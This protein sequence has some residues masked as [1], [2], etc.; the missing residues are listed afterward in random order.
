MQLPL[1][2]KTRM[3]NQLGQNF[4]KFQASLEGVP[5]VSIR[6]NPRKVAPIIY[7]RKQVVWE[8]LAFYLNERP[9][10]T[11]DPQFHAGAYYVQEASSMFVGYVFKQ[12][13]KKNTPLKILDLCGAPGGKSTH[14]ASLMNDSS[15]LV[16][17]E[18][19]KTR[20]AVLTENLI[21]LGNPNLV[22]TQND[23]KDFQKLPGFF[24]LILVDAPC[25]GEGLFRRD[26]SAM[27]EW[28]VDN[29]AICSQRQQRILADVWEALAPGGYLIYSTCTYNPDENERNLSW[30]T[31]QFDAVNV[32]IIIPDEWG[33][34]KINYQNIEAYQFFPHNIEG[35]GFFI[36]VLQKKGLEQ[37]LKNRT[38]KKFNTPGKELE[39]IV[40]RWLVQPEYFKFIELNQT[41]RAIPS[42]LQP[43]IELLSEQ[44]RIVHS[45]ILIAEIKGKKLIPQHDLSMS[46]FLNKGQF[47]LILLDDYEALLYLKK[48]NVHSDQGVR[49]FNI[50]MH[51]KLPLGFVNHLGNRSNNNYPV[52]WRIRMNLPVKEAFVPHVIVKNQEI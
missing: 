28:S 47:P 3:Q 43:W 44:L 8:P 49:G 51:D 27:D 36:G 2:F 10:F 29:A 13:F 34:S 35:E 31:D 48:E 50:M 6:I 52:N 32:P 23:P 14:I 26:E 1:A 9:I 25:S 11:L 37:P 24:D 12:L 45:G 46:W 22:V 39:A 18:V 41:I 30:I 40:T 38:K 15:F 20:T 4:D 19:I 16:S 7:E 5:P 42:P 33:I 21:K 17:N